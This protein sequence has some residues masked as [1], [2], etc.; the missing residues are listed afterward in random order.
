MSIKF[1]QE[2]Y[3]IAQGPEYLLSIQHDALVPYGAS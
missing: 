1:M 3:D 2:Q